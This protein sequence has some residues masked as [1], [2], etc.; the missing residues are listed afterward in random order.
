MTH[1]LNKNIFNLKEKFLFVI[2][3]YYLQTDLTNTTLN[4]CIDGEFVKEKLTYKF[5]D[6]NK[7]PVVC[8]CGHELEKYRSK[9]QIVFWI[10]SSQFTYNIDSS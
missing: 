3:K 10:F 4:V 9:T 1:N 7:H 8:R 2:N 5:N 6:F